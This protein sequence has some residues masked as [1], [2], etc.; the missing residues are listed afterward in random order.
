[1]SRI[2]I[3]GA[4]AWGTAL[5]IVL[6]RNGGHAVTLWAHETEVFECIVTRH[7][8]S[9]YLPGCEVPESVTPTNDLA[10][11]L[12]DAEIVL[13]VMPSHHCRNIFRQISPHLNAKMRFVSATKGVENSSLLRMSEVISETVFLEAGFRPRIAVLSGPS[14]ARETAK[15]DPTALTVAA[16][17]PGLSNS[18]QQNFSGPTFRIYTSE[19]VIG[20]ELGGA[21]KNVIAIAAGIVEGLGFGHNTAA[22]LITRGLAEITRLSVACGA[23]A[24]TMAGLAGMGDLVLTC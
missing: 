5:A 23:R 13:S 12:K 14:F 15:G 6:G 10:A 9:V 22:A 4:G 20:V 11:A 16:A 1:M 2:G 7:E 3:I 21:L 17:D 8:N 19:D 18:V 24:D